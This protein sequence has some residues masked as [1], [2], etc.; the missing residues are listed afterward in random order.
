MRTYFTN[1]PTDLSSGTDKS[2][3][4]EKDDLII[5]LTMI[6]L[7]TSQDRPDRANYF[8]AVF[9]TVYEEALGEDLNRPDEDAGPRR[10]LTPGDYWLNPFEQTSP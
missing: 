9:K 7:S 6:W 4:D 2:D 3:L 1:W 5:L 8:W 10:G